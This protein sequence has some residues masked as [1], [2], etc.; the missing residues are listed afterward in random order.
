MATSLLNARPGAILVAARDMSNLTHLQ[1][2]LRK[3]NLRRHDIIV[4][5]VRPSTGDAFTDYERE[6]FSKVVSMAE[7]EGKTVELLVVPGAEPFDAIVHTAHTLGVS[8]VVIGGS[9]RMDTGELARKIG[10]AWEKLAEPRHPFSL[11]ILTPGQPSHFVNLGPHPPR[12]WPEDI[13]KVHELWL[14]LTAGE[15]GSKLHHRDVVAAALRRFERDLQDPA[16]AQ[17]VQEEVVHLRE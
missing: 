12:L 17:Q 2:V 16:S 9:L 11:E 5:T 4:M 6:L 10:L 15:H 8:R 13:T 1:S 14:K 3:T 7:K